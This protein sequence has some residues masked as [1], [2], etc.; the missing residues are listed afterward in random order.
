MYT[1]F[2]DIRVEDTYFVDIGS[3]DIMQMGIEQVGMELVLIQLVYSHRSSLSRYPQFCPT[4][5]GMLCSLSHHGL[6]ICRIYS[7][8]WPV[9]L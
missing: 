6:V 8:N 1:G 2:V 5:D 7:I 4:I 3:V 9:H